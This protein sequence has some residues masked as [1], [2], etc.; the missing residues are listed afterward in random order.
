MDP[1]QQRFV[2]R[3]EDAFLYVV[4]TEA[5]GARYRDRSQVVVYADDEPM[6][7]LPSSSTQWLWL[8][9]DHRAEQ[10]WV[11]RAADKVVDGYRLDDE[12]RVSAR[13][14]LTMSPADYERHVREYRFSDD[15]RYFYS[16][17][18]H[19]RQRERELFADDAGN[20]P[21]LDGFA[22]EYR[23]DG[24]PWVPSVPAALLQR[25]EYHHLFPGSLHG[26]R[27]HL[28]ERIRELPAV[29]YAFNEKAAGISVVLALA[30][31][32]PDT[33]FG[34]DAS[35]R[36]VSRREKVERRLHL[37]VPNSVA[38]SDYRDALA[39]WD[40]E[41]E[42][43]LAAVRSVTVD[44]C[45][46][47]DGEGYLHSATPK[48]GTPATPCVGAISPTDPAELGAWLRS[49]PLSAILRDARRHAWERNTGVQAA[50]GTQRKFPTLIYAMSGGEFELTDGHYELAHLTQYAP[51]T[52][53]SL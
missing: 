20:W 13:Y 47:C 8:A 36:T 5:V 25:P 27:Q 21:V 4:P 15:E 48:D 26:L 14:P 2:I 45:V 6:R 12:T 39:A 42:R 35:V 16:E 44:V 24:P 23:K 19:E 1:T 49:L 28:T 38:G 34:S 46:H 9:A 52:L 17:I 43:W 40:I 50:R 51:F 3:H 53:L 29:R 7:Q 10:V 11:R 31:T 30:F 37:N 41:V 22:P 18:S 33:V 32:K